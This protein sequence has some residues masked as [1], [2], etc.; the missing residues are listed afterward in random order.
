MK[1]FSGL[2]RKIAL[3]LGVCLAI[4]A[5]AAPDASVVNPRYVLNGDTV[6]DKVANLTW[7]RCSVGQSWKQDSGCVGSVK[8]F[9]FDEAQRLA[10]GVWR[11]PTKEELAS[12]IDP[13]RQAEPR[14]DVTVFPNMDLKDLFYWSSSADGDDSGW[15]V[16][17]SLGRMSRDRRAAPGPVR[18]VRDG[19]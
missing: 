18:L 5:Q 13:E 7:Q 9:T 15:Y 8:K 14:L 19:Q 6:Y 16:G 12:L 1:A 11:V 2:P 4:V 17:F 10:G 3:M